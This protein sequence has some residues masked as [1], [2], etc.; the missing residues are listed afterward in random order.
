MNRTRM[1]RALLGAAATFTL[2]AAGC[3]AGGTNHDGMATDG[4]TGGT[5]G[6]ITRGPA[7]DASAHNDADVM[8][9]QMMIPHHEQAVEM[10]TL[11]ETRA[12]DPELARLAA[13][14]KGAQGP[15][16]TTMTGWLTAWGQPILDPGEVGGM[17][18]GGH[19]GG[20]GMM[21]AAEMTQLAAASGV[22]FDRLFARMM[23]AH[24]NGAIQMAQA[25]ESAGTHP[26]VRALAKAILTSQAAE[27][28]TLQKISDRL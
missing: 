4:T 7:G 15:E 19:G 1:R 6:A 3:G 22:G 25:H 9:V 18:H 8:F 13:A 14:I 24:H 21:P 10:A 12:G 11:A 23:I 28:Q 27:V 2:L 16:I 5:T 26:E 20:S 17:S